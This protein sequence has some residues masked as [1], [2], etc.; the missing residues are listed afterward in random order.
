MNS[1][2]QIDADDSLSYYVYF[3]MK[4]PVTEPFKLENVIYVGKGKHNRW[5]QHFEATVKKE[6][7]NEELSEKEEALREI[8]DRHGGDKDV[9]NFAYSVQW[10]LD[11]SSAL[12]LE[13]LLIKIL[14]KQP[15]VEL[16]NAAAGHHQGEVF[17][18]VGE[19]RRYFGREDLVVER[20]AAGELGSFL[21][22]S[23]RG[24]DDLCIL[25]KGTSKE[26]GPIRREVVLNMPPQVE[27]AVPVEAVPEE[28]AYRRGWDP[29]EPWTLE[30]ASER[31]RRYWSISA[32]NV[33][34]L[35]AIADDGR[36]R[37]AML[38]RD[39]QHRKSVVRYTWQVE[40]GGDWFEYWGPTDE[41]GYR[42]SGKYGVPLG[43][44]FAESEDD[45]LGKSPVR[46][47]GDQFLATLTAGIG[48]AVVE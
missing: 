43:R 20:V 34:V 23:S 29:T 35:R 18:P 3:L 48:Y 45:W 44:A 19:A 14:A 33:Q 46:D 41:E 30:E 31:A 5:R 21:P 28:D 2:L 36:L 12:R 4:E 42:K 32:E 10:G 37:L 17:L 27:G 9:E 39:P 24:E 16:K 25:V 13:A 11:E 6:A 22:G 47:D 8:M 26:L 38:V 40:P 7:S 15:G 1:K